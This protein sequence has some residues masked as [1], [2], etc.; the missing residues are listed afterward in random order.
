MVRLFV[1]GATPTNWQLE[2]IFKKLDGK[3]GDH[4]FF[5]L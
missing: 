5:V 1:R 2:M 3:L 4:Q